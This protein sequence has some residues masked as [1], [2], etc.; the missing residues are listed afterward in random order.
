MRRHRDQARWK[1]VDRLTVMIS[2]ANRQRI[3]DGLR[4]GAGLGGQSAFD[5]GDRG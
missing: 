1:L 5:G 4:D 2:F 3:V